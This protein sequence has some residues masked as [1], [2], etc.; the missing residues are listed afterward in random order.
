MP[1]PLY[2]CYVLA[3][4]RSAEIAIRFLSHFMPERRP[5]FDPADPHEVLGVPRDSTDEEVFRFLESNV[6]RAY[7]MH[8]SNRRS[9]SPYN[10]IVSFTVDG[11]LILGLSPSYDDEEVLARQTLREL[12]Q[13]AAS[14]LAYAGVE[15]APAMSRADFVSRVKTEAE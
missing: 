5:S 9:G 1:G 11:C 3:P 4:L 7:S 15:E 2:D 14:S 8:W 6:T 10:A 12:K 13:F